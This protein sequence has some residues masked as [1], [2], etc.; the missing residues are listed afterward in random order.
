MLLMMLLLV[1]LLFG[2]VD[3]VAVDVVAV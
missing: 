2:D 1:M 3:G